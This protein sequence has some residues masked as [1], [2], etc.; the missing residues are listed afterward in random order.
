MKG[1][2]KGFIKGFF[3]IDNINCFYESDFINIKK[4]LIS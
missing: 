1:F 3:F 4:S 2:I